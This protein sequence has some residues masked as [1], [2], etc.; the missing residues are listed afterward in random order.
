MLPN[1]LLPILSLSWFPM[2]VT[3]VEINVQ[4][5]TKWDIF[6]VQHPDYVSHAII[7]GGD[8]FDFIVCIA[9]FLSKYKLYV[10]ITNTAW[11]SSVKTLWRI[12]FLCKMNILMFNYTYIIWPK[13]II[14]FSTRLYFAQ[15]KLIQPHYHICL[16]KIF[17][18]YHENHL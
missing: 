3:K 2:V 11:N 9:L 14:H 13:L 4:L 16:D 1:Y 10:T 5:Q 12:I 6:F 7:Q 17:N 15:Y 8:T 18:S